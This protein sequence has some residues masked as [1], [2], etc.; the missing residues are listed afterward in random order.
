MLG[1]VPSRLLDCFCI[2]QEPIARKVIDD[3]TYTKQLK[4]EVYLHRLK[5]SCYNNSNSTDSDI[6]ADFSRITT[7]GTFKMFETK[8]VNISKLFQKL[9]TNPF[10]TI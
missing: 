6:T 1:S 4:V 10:H 7:I 3:G 9:N 8:G 5:L 2:L